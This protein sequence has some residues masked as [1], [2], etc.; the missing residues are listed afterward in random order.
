M[1][2][3]AGKNAIISKLRL[4]DKHYKTLRD[5]YHNC[6]INLKTFNTRRKNLNERVR[7]LR[8]ELRGNT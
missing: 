5:K 2:P 7:E 6:K 1:L 4:L 3:K 8:A